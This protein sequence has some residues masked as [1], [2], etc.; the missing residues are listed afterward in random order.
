MIPR[1]DAL[2]ILLTTVKDEVRHLDYPRVTQLADTY[3]MYITGKGIDAVLQQFNPRE[4]E[5]MFKQR[6]ALTIPIT[7]ACL[8]SV[9][10]PFNKVPRTPPVTKKITSKNEKE[11]NSPAVKEIENAI[12]N[13]Y[14]GD[15]NVGGLD[16]FLQNRFVDM[17]WNDPNAWVVV[18]FDA[19]DSTKE[20]A[21]PRPFEVS[22]KQAI[23]FN[24]VNNI[25]QWL[26]VE[27]DTTYKEKDGQND[28]VIKPGKKYT[29]YSEMFSLVLEE[30]SD[31]DELRVVEGTPGR[32]IVSIEKQGSFYSDYY[33]HKS[34]K[35]PAFRVGY[36]RDIETEGRTFV[37][38]FHDALCF[39]QKSIKQGSE[40][41]FST[42]L[43]V[44]PQKIIRVTGKCPGE[45]SMP[46]N[47]GRLSDGSTCGNCK[48]TGR[49]VHTSGQD[50]I[51]VQLPE[52]KEDYVALSDFVYYVQ[53]PI[54]L[55][56]LQK[57]WL[58]SLKVDVHQ[59]IF[60]SDVLLRKSTGFTGGSNIDVTAT[61]KDQDLESVYDALAPFGEKVSSVWQT[62]VELIAV[63]TDNFDKVTIIHRLPTKYKLK[64]RIDLYNERAALM[65]SGAPA[66][67]IDSVDEE[68][69]QD[70]YTDNA[71]G[72][73][74]YTVKKDHYPFVG[75][76]Q[77]EILGLLTSTEVLKST[78][79][80]YNYF[81][82]IFTELEREQNG[83]VK[84]KDLYLLPFDK[85]KELIDAK[86]Q[87]IIDKLKAENTTVI[88]FKALGI[89]P[90]KLDANGNPMVDENGNAIDANGNPIIDP[91]ADPNATDPNAKPDPGKTDPNANPGKK[92]NPFAKKPE[93]VA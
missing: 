52:V 30:T 84:E 17:G 80:L 6:I 15:N 4:D 31:S 71:D 8:S 58:D 77:N 79:V 66:F 29:M 92:P 40:Y 51:E 45:R 43:H 37:A 68:L 91:N 16:Y 75:K 2:Q 3:Y 70:I 87:E 14:G 90:P 28:E 73:L 34:P 60:N 86:V 49:P 11:K 5:I 26:I 89:I 35:T 78:K 93:P 19:F 38:P 54:D 7:P 76:T 53:L 25:V 39:L 72:M 82:E 20:K 18:E 67:A 81:D 1:E 64:S 23:N 21:K 85:R 13:F 12:A 55:L 46:C 59:T 24:I 65:N 61:E 74:R 88:D 42:N 10:K 27:T 62:I 32:E 56:R 44:F 33:E 47:K 48:G 9:K 63:F 57:E 36:V 69:A 22:S 83:N 50:V 41:D